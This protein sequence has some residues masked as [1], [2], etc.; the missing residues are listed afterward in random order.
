MN[1]KEGSI[2]SV[3]KEFKSLILKAQKEL[4]ARDERFKKHKTIHEA[5]KK[6]YQTLYKE[7]QE[8]RKKLQQYEAYFK[9]YQKEKQK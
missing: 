3:T 8:L 2:Q 9:N 4:K 1:G 5:T 7:N 6:Q